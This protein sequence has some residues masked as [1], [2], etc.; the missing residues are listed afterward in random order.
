M[1]LYPP[2][3]ERT[4]EAWLDRGLA[5]GENDGDDPWSREVSWAFDEVRQRDYTPDLEALRRSLKGGWIGAI[6]GLGTYVV[7]AG[8]PS[9]DDGSAGALWPEDVVESNL[10]DFT[11]DY[12][13]F[14]WRDDV[15]CDLDVLEVLRE[16]IEQWL[17]AAYIEAGLVFLTADP[18]GEPLWLEVERVEDGDD[19]KTL[20]LRLAGSNWWG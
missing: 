19:G 1:A 15:E 18:S 7:R 20:E 16:Q 5:L 10:D 14:L 17:D 12:R 8:E 13:F 3:P 9:C 4:L 6:S 2:D 11:G